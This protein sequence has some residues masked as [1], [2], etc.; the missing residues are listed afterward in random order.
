[1]SFWI[2]GDD[3]QN[4]KRFYRARFSF[5]TPLITSFLPLVKT[6]QTEFQIRTGKPLK[7]SIICDFLMIGVNLNDST[8]LEPSEKVL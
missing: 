1:M 3:F 8:T 6:K 4:S 2:E 7:L 5:Q